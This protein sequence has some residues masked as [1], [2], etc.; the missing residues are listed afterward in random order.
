VRLP[1]KAGLHDAIVRVSIELGSE[2]GEEGLTMRAIA[3]RLGVSATA[4]YQHF[5]SK[6]AILREIRLYGVRMLQDKL[7]AK[8]GIA[9]P[10]QKLTELGTCYVDFAMENPWLYKVLFF[11]DQAEWEA[12]Q[13]QERGELL[14]PLQ[15]V[16]RCIAD[17]IDGGSFRRDL[18]VDHMVLMLWSS[19]HGLAI[20]MLDGRIST[21]HP[22]FPIRDVK[23]FVR[24]YIA[25]VAEA[26]TV[27]PTR[28]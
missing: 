25:G 1:A 17:G 2:L 13:E 26:L 20:M 24:G 9:D 12:A 18:S 28:A 19:M 6:G 16:R 21:D 23:R 14:A 10:V 15:T 11:G 5:E 7:D 22:V 4:L 27:G 3:A 8:S